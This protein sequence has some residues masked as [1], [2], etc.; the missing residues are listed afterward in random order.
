M[1]KFITVE[2]NVAI[3]ETEQQQNPQ[4]NPQKK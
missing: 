4:K 2:V 3:T 1:L